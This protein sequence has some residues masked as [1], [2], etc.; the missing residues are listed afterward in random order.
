[1]SVRTITYN[2]NGDSISPD[3]LQ[4][5]GVR[6]EDNA[7]TVKFILDDEFKNKISDA[8]YDAEI[9]YRIDFDGAVSGYNPSENIKE[10]GGAV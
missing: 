4:Y 10:N 2:F 9:V 6:Y 7:T 3:T 8:F 5:G 1:M